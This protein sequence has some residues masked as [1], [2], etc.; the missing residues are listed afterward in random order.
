MQLNETKSF[1]AWG[2][3]AEVD[4]SITSL[5]ALTICLPQLL[6][7]GKKISLDEFAKVAFFK[8]TVTLDPATLEQ[9]GA[10]AV[11]PG[12]SVVVPAAAHVSTVIPREVCR[13]AVF[14]LIVIWM[15][16]RSGV[17]S[18]AVEVLTNLLNAD[19]VPSFTSVA[20]APIELLRV[21]PSFNDTERRNILQG[22]FVFTGMAGFIGGYVQKTFH[23]LDVVAAF[24]CE[25]AGVA[26]GDS[27]D[28]AVFELLRPQRGQMSSAS[29]LRLM[30]DSSR[31]TTASSGT[32]AGAA[33]AVFKAIPQIH[34]PALEAS[35]A[36][37]RYVRV[38]SILHVNANRIVSKVHVQQKTFVVS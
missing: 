7:G 31:N 21:T 1:S 12:P 22:E 18:S 35:A 20:N 25:A 32:C 37:A 26:L 33:E 30:L 28:P 3:E 5:S 9:V 4:K 17:R 13:A 38:V 23:T 15:Q 19:R 11:T 27:S 2:S 24:S 29:N 14:Q 16:G 34:G 6:V 36:S 8:A 10:K